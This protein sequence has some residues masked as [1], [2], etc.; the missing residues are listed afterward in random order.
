MSA[1]NVKKFY[2]AVSQDEKAKQRFNELNQKYQGVAMNAAKTD[3]I[4]EQELL[5]LAKEL[6]FEFTLAEIKAY[7]VEVEQMKSSCALSDSELEV[8]SGSDW[9]FVSAKIAL[10]CTGYGYPS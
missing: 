4:L 1:E 3:A 2:E 6:G 8:V 10:R 5:P 9:C 7:G